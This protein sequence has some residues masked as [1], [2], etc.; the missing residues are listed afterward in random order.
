MAVFCN[1]FTIQF[2]RSL[3]LGVN[4][5][6]IVAAKLFD[7]KRFWH[8][9]PGDDFATKS[10]NANRIITVALVNPQLSVQFFGL[11]AIANMDMIFAKPVNKAIINIRDSLIQDTK[12]RIFFALARLGKHIFHF[13]II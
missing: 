3:A 12:G 8:K 4:Y 9:N 13:F 7:F 10:G 11:P 6:P 2:V 5:C 1:C